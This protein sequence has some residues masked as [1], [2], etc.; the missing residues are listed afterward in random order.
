MDRALIVFLCLA[1]LAGCGS[2][3]RAMEL[4]AG[5]VELHSEM[6]VP[7][8][9]EVRGAASGTT[10]RAAADFSG[11]ALLVVDGANV[12][13]QNLNVDGN[14]GALEKR[15]GLPAYDVPFV[16]FTRANG[17]LAENVSSLTVTRVQFREVAGFAILVARGH[18]IV[19]NHLEIS[20]SGSRN[21]AGRNNTTGGILLEE[22]TT[23]FQITNC[24]LRN[25]RGNGIWTHS[26]YTSPRNDTGLIRDNS[27]LQ[28]ARDAIQVGHATRV[29]VE[30]N[31]GTAIGMPSEDVD[32]ENRA[33]PVAIDTAGNVDLSSYSGNRFEEING[34]CIDLDGFHNGEIRGNTCINRGKPE[35]YPFGHF[36][37]VMN[38]SNPD[39]Q[40]QNIR[41]LDNVI[42]GAKFGGIFVI[43]RGHVV[44]NNHLRNINTAHCNEDAA[45]FGC[46]YT[47]GE[48]D[49]LRS[50]IYL[51]RGAER[52]AP[53][54]SNTIED[55]EISG[56]QMK[57]RCVV[58]APGIEASWN[59]VRANK[60][61]D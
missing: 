17:I 8:N 10:L 38:N 27:I 23:D 49:M 48:P 20:D 22:G 21:A 12:R 6:H 29:R 37:I 51:G 3:R 59:V 9:T 5:V 43:G 53:A 33:T 60:C 14:R 54:R 28:V 34:K 35:A 52:P 41:V 7:A 44:T 39:M 2:N 11:R 19:L 1:G 31:V 32:V 55:N 24:T 15:Q 45:R 46:Y 36:G 18:G 58:A 16:N 50:G 26:L 40:S 57:T 4:A 25:I 47:A 56:F 61:S 13:I 42:E 30:N